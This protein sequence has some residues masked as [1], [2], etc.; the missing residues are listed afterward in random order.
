MKVL[1]QFY[2]DK[3]WVKISLHFL[4]IS[5]LSCQGESVRYKRGDVQ[6]IFDKQGKMAQGG[7]KFPKGIKRFSIHQ[8]WNGAQNGMLHFSVGLSKLL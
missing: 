7:C 3:C 6:K 8:N 1:E 5:S 4:F 2:D